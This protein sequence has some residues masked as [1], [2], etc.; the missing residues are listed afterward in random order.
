MAERKRAKQR[1]RDRLSAKKAEKVEKFEMINPV[2]KGEAT[3]AKAAAAKKGKAKTQKGKK[4]KGVA[5]DSDESL[6]G[7]IVADDAD[8]KPRKKAKTAKGKK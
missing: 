2:L 8:V 4:K 6:D 7:F 1:E 3:R 5:D